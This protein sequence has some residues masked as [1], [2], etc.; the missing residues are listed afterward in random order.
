MLYHYHY[1]L[2]LAFTEKHHVIGYCDTVTAMQGLLTTAHKEHS[3]CTS[4]CQG[5]VNFENK[6]E[7]VNIQRK[8]KTNKHLSRAVK[9]RFDSWKQ[10]VRKGYN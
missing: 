8:V 2:K 1:L 7:N 6:F 9:Y 5:P 10:T 3:A 4:F